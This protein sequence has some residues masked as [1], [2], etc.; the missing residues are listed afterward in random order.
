M[1]NDPEVMRWAAEARRAYWA[2]RPGGAGIQ[3]AP[4]GF[5][6]GDNVIQFAMQFC[7]DYG[8]RYAAVLKAMR[9]VDAEVNRG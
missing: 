6:G 5:Y 2:N 1:A 8:G 9:K 3:S 7:R 4:V